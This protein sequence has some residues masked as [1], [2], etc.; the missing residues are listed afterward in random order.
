ME[1]HHH[2][3]TARKKWAHY[4][5]EFLMLFLA[6]FCG[7]L[8]EY[9][10]EHKIEKTREKQY[11]RSFLEDLAA[12]TVDLARSAA[13]CE[14]TVRRTDSLIALLSDPN[15]ENAAGDIYYFLRVI[16]RSDVFSL[17]DRTIVQL[18]NAGGMRLVSKKA[19]AD[20]MVSYY[21]QADF[22]RFIYEE[23]TEFR[24]S[25]RPHFPKILDGLEYAY[26]INDENEV[27]RSDK[28][29]KLR[30]ADPETINTC[31]LILQNIKGINLGIRMR[32]LQ[33]SEKAKMIRE[34]IKDTY[35]MKD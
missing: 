15:R 11:I 25:L 5:W 12:D 34:F 13:Y 23:Q 17:N 27:I 9:Q 29:L 2:A 1:V 6:V 3:H 21:K 31:I 4:F 19:V 26:V 8:A 24:R 16:H 18:R 20:S 14:L 22:I 28:P 33:F 7:F 35:H 10:L 30:S 32:L